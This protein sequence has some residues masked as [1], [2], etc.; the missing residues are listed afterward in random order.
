M[1]FNQISLADQI[2]VVAVKLNEKEFTDWTHRQVVSLA[3]FMQSKG[4]DNPYET[5]KQFVFDQMNE[6]IGAS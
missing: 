1:E 5:A 6:A 4:I 3:E 2:K